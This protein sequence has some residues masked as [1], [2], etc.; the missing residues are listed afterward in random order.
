MQFVNKRS[1]F[2][3][4]SDFVELH[5]TRSLQCLSCNGGNHKLHIYK[6]GN[7]RSYRGAE[8]SQTEGLEKSS[9]SNQRDAMRQ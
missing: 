3:Y 7:T 9:E 1:S 5:L 6:T 4:H 2:P 8:F